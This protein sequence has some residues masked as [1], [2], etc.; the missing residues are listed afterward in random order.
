MKIEMDA[1]VQEYVFRVL[2]EIIGPEF[3]DEKARV[4]L[5]SQG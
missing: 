5:P 3:A 4:T 2:A 1:A